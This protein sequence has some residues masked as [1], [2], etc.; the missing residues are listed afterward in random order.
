MVRTQPVSTLGVLAAGSEG[1]DASQ[2]GEV[3]A[4][5]E[6]SDDIMSS[7]GGVQVPPEEDGMT[8]EGKSVLQKKIQQLEENNRRVLSRLKFLE[9][10]LQTKDAAIDRLNSRIEVCC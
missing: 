4:A 2:C 7:V 8:V 10:R 5:A 3:S 1:V 9:S 6:C